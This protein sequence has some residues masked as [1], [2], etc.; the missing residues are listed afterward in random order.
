MGM[1]TRKHYFDLVKKP[2]DVIRWWPCWVRGNAVKPRWPGSL[3]PPVTRSMHLAITDV[4]LDE[5]WVV[6]PGTRAYAL[7]DR[8]NVR[9]LKDCIQPRKIPAGA[10]KKLKR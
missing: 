1:V 8:I 9:P 2:W 7:A 10:T 5:L 3:C 6:Y 4:G